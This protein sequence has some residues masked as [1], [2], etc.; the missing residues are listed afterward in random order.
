M[1]ARGRSGRSRTPAGLPPPLPGSGSLPRPALALPATGSPRAVATRLRAARALELAAA[2]APEA[3][4][5]LLRRGSVSAKTQD[6]YGLYLA[7]LQHY[8]STR[9]SPHPL[10]E[11][12]DQTIVL[13]LYRQTSLAVDLA[14]LGLERGEGAVLDLSPGALRQSSGEAAAAW[15]LGPLGPLV[16]YRVRHAG[17]S[18]DFA[19]N[20]RRLEEI[21][22]RGRWQSIR[23]LRLYEHGGRLPDL[24][25]A[26]AR[27][28]SGGRGGRSG[29]PQRTP[30]GA[31]AFLGPLTAPTVA[32]FLE[33]FAGSGHLSDAVERGNVPTLRWDVL[34]GP[35]YDLRNPKN[36]RLLRG[37]IR[38]GLVCGMHAGFPCE[39]FSR[40]RD[41]PNG[42]PRLRSGEHVWGLPSLPAGGADSEKVK[43]GNHFAKLT[44]SLCVLCCQ[45][46]VPWSI[47]NPALS[48]A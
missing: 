3:Q 25:P 17:A 7:A 35:A 47:E 29:A 21:Q 8:Y 33:L 14:Q 26:A 1:L 23:S 24:A 39:T 11:V 15:R 42:P 9:G 5:S 36:A 18:V 46:V 38:A 22:R 32:V 2:R 30:G 12:F 13:D 48:Y 34:Y 43:W 4:M 40:A 19:T 31:P 28:A 37:W 45:C 20:G 10:T 16:A 44:I 27:R 6:R 41:R